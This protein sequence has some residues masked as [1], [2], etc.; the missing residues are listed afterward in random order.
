[1]KKL[2]IFL[3]SAFPFYNLLFAQQ[4]SIITNVKA[5]VWSDSAT[6][7]GKKIPSDSDIV[8]LTQDLIIDKEAWC[9]IFNTNGYKTVI[10]SG[11]HLNIGGKSNLAPD[12]FYNYKIPGLY[13]SDTLQAKVILGGEIEFFIYGLRDSA[14]KIAQITSAQYRR[15][16]NLD[17]IVNLIY[18]DSLRV[19]ALYISIKGIKDSNLVK[20]F[21][22]DSTVIVTRYAV[23]WYTNIC[24]KREVEISQKKHSFFTFTKGAIYSQRPADS[25]SND[26]SQIIP[27]IASGQISGAQMLSNSGIAK[28]AVIFKSSI[29]T[30][31][32]V[33][34][35]VNGVA[36]TYI[37]SAG[38]VEVLNYNQ[39][40]LQIV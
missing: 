37:V 25:I 4:T 21:Y 28:G 3:L 11:A 5:G 36:N 14:G 24:E 8:F 9:L 23:N 27:A 17:T 10:N 39:P 35:F 16:N 2:L 34:T 22:G 30:K 19:S 1:M 38:L 32:V 31:L 12:S 7:D 20:Y 29:I 33:Y 6:W 15:K 26:W 40:P 13:N 18:D